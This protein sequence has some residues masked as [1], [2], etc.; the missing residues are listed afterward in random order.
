MNRP[1]ILIVDDQQIILFLLETH[2][3]Q[4]GFVP[5]TASSGAEAERGATSR[6]A[7]RRRR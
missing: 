5:V 2:L 1:T 3:R 4:A 7:P 6:P